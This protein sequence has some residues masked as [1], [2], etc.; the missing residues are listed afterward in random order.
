MLLLRTFLLLA[1]GLSINTSIA[2]ESFEGSNNV[3]LSGEPP[4]VTAKRK[5]GRQRSSGD[6]PDAKKTPNVWVLDI[7]QRRNC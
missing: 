4:I 7:Y 5:D 1:F 2:S 3:Y 6:G